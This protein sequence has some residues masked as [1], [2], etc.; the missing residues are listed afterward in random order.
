MII[1][2]TASYERK[3]KKLIN[4]DSKLSQK[5]KQKLQ[6]LQKNQKHPSLRLH[7]LSGK[8]N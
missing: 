5:I 4:R 8:K 2:L 7:K 6:L 3:H 1:Y